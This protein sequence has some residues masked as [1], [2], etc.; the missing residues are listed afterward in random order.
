MPLALARLTEEDIMS[1]D[2]IRNSGK[3]GFDSGRTGENG[4]GAGQSIFN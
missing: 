1:E 4:S 2:E 3:S